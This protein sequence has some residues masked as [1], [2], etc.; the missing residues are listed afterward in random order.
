MKKYTI[1]L[2]GQMNGFY[3]IQV[4][5]HGVMVR[6]EKDF[7]TIKAATKRIEEIKEEGSNEAAP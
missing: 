6:E 3:K 4:Y 1:T 2:M 7:P 5:D